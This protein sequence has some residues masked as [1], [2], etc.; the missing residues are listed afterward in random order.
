MTMRQKFILGFLTCILLSIL[1]ISAISLEKILDV[2]ATSVEEA[3]LKQLS[4]ADKYLRHMFEGNLSRLEYL[5]ICRRCASA[6][7]ISPRRR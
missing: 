5:H 3:S 4:L 2:S 7:G 1:S 6:A